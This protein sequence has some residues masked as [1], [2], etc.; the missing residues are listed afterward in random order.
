MKSQKTKIKSKT[1]YTTI[2]VP[3]MLAKK[4]EKRIENTGF[5]SLSGFITYVM[6][7]LLAEE[8]VARDEPLSK[9]DM[10][11]VRRKLRALGYA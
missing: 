10:E 5:G 1:R 3:T 6:R 2:C 4:I 11:I 7:E 8:K 9:N